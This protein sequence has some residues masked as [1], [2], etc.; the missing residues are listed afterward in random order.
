MLKRIVCG[1]LALT[2]AVGLT[3]CGEKESS[4]K[5]RIQETTQVKVEESVAESEETPEVITTE[6]PQEEVTETEEL[7]MLCIYKSKTSLSYSDY[8]RNN[9]NCINV[10]WESFALS[11]EDMLKYPALAD[12]LEE[13]FG[14]LGVSVYEAMNSL[15]DSYVEMLEWQDEVYG[16]E[17]STSYSILRA[18]SNV[19]SFLNSGYSYYGGAHGYYYTSGVAFDV[20]TGKQLNV[21]DVV[22]DEE[23]FK[24]VVAEYLDQEYG[25]IFFEDIYTT[26]QEYTMDQFSW[27][28]SYS[29][30]TLFFN[31]YELA[32]Y[33]DGMQIFEMPYAQYG[34]LFDEK[35]NVMP[36]Q[37]IIPMQSENVY[38]L[39][40]N[41]DG[42]AENFSYGRR[43]TGDEEFDYYDNMI[44]TIT[45]NGTTRDCFTADYSA[46]AYFV[47]KKTN[48]YLYIFHEV[49]NDD[50][51]LEIIDLSTGENVGEEYEFYNLYLP[52]Q[53]DY[54]EDTEA[55]VVYTKETKLEFLNPQN[56]LFG[57][58]LDL[59]S[60]YG[61]SRWY[62]IGED[63]RPAAKDA[64]YDASVYFLIC[65][66][67]DIPCQI[68]NQDGVVQN[69]N[70][71]LPAGTYVK[72]LRALDGTVDV[73]PALA[74][75]PGEDNWY[76]EEYSD[77]AYDE[78]TIYRIT[79]D[80]DSNYT[81]GGEDVYS[82]FEGLLYAG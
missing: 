57:S 24:A 27:S 4:R 11:E 10:D 49:E 68:V 41:K 40:V 3:A 82:L 54:N 38:T 73:I 25:D 76:F 67:E 79:L 19:L 8:E 48:G 33:A 13:K 64:Y 16:L 2:L 51:V 71:I 78:K 80:A 45:W 9:F 55:D 36:D 23:Q 62:E 6:E 35:Y 29:G 32:S 47:Q 74:Y 61:A 63:G 77:T 14:T 17:D 53:Y 58:R 42:I 70:A 75:E 31:P 28:I 69:A 12:T 7:E 30:I 39:D 1:M 60:T 81:I 46:K 44:S 37:Y 50:T 65:A 66:K 22:T 72:I 15:K 20:A 18:D 21:G 5:D 34:Y 56:V 26:I 52:G 43:Y 59:L